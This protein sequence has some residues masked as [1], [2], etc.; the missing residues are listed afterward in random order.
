[1]RQTGLTKK[2]KQS[3]TKKRPHIAGVTNN[4]RKRKMNY[5]SINEMDIA[6]GTG[7]RVN[8]FVS[9]CTHHCKG[10]FNP[11]AWDFNYGK[12]FTEKTEQQII[13]YMNFDYI[14]GITILGGEPMEPE[15]QKALLPFIKKIKSMFPN[16]DIWIYS[17]YTLEEMLEGKLSKTAT[18][19]EILKTADILV[20]GEFI[21]TKKNL[22]L[23]FRGSSNQ[24]II[25]IKKSLKEN[26][27]VIAQI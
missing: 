22:K 26:K 10:C 7:L 14:K 21:E 2:S 18:T 17:G 20:D 1:M 11:E 12:K 8:L 9:G 27:P 6:N 16:K 24:R 3:K 25:D 15:N 13:E 5:A 4:E 23:K 19:K